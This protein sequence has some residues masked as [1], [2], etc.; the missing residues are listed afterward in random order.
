[1]PDTIEALD[2]AIEELEHEAERIVC[3]N[4]DVLR[5]YQERIKSV[6]C[7]THAPVLLG[8]K[9]PF[10]LIGLFDIGPLGIFSSRL[11]RFFVY[12]TASP[13]FVLALPSRD[14]R[15]SEFKH[16]L[17]LRISHR[18]IRLASLKRSPQRGLFFPPYFPS[19]IF[20]GD[21]K[22][23]CSKLRDTLP[24]VCPSQIEELEKKLEEELSGQAGRHDR[25]EKLKVS[26][27]PY[28]L[29]ERPQYRAFWKCR[30]LGRKDR[31][32]SP[33]LSFSDL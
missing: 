1:L 22:P 20:R 30:D 14:F 32:L 26:V 31:L 4:P 28:N 11:C 10:V 7:L 3:D 21:S 9:D 15:F 2:E 29:R 23:R 18:M 6:S 17:T 27:T 8:A 24:L 5:Q 16:L 13:L 25:I 12:G 33:Q 19:T